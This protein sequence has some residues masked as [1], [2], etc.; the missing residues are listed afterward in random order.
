[1]QPKSRRTGQKEHEHKSLLLV[2]LVSAMLLPAARADIDVDIHLGR[3]VPP[4]PPEVVVV[5]RVGP[6]APPPWAALRPSQPAYSYYYYPDADVY[7]RA[8][9]HMWFYQ[10]GRNWRTTRQLPSGIRVDFGR[11]VPLRLDS[12]RPYIYHDRV[13]AYYPRNYFT[14]VKFKNYHDYHDRHDDHHDDHRDD[15]DRNHH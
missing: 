7:Y 9:T 3:A 15:H 12:D 8:D 10:D 14:R 5:D 4:P 2:S 6:P 11:S 1:M 13:V